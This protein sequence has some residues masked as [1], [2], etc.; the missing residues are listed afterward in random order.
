[1]SIWI[2]HMFKNVVSNWTRKEFI[3]FVES[4]FVS[5]LNNNSKKILLIIVTIVVHMNSVDY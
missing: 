1:M 4:I 5:Q 2:N 3:S